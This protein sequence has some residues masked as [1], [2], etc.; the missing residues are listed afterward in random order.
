MLFN[1]DIDIYRLEGNSTPNKNPF[2]TKVQVEKP[3]SSIKGRISRTSITTKEGINKQ[4]SGSF[5]L[6]CSITE[7][8]IPGDRIHDVLNDINYLVEFVYKPNNHHIEA[9]LTIARKDI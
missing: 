1:Q 2:S 4:T 7:D 5:R 8:V 6:Y 3:T 9:D